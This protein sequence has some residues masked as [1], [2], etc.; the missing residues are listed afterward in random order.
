MSFNQ[1]SSVLVTHNRTINDFQEVSEVLFYKLF[2][3]V[4][5]RS[6]H[7]SNLQRD[8]D[9]AEAEFAE[10]HTLPPLR[11]HESGLSFSKTDDAEDRL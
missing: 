8:E 9:S 3:L 10:Q 5:L 7:H 11:K 4:H 6:S 2:Q 1:Y